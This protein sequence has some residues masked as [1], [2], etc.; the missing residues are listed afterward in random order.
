MKA[1]AQDE[2][3]AGC[4]L[5]FVVLMRGD[6]SSHHRPERQGSHIENGTSRRLNIS[7]AEQCGN[8]NLGVEGGVRNGVKMDEKPP[9][10]QGQSGADGGVEG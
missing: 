10:E 7:Y 8:V 9:R 4:C 3:R 2:Q 1:M 6:A 5:C